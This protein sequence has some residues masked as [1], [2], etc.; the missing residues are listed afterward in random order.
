MRAKTTAKHAMARGTPLKGITSMVNNLPSNQSTRRFNKKV[1]RV[2]PLEESSQLNTEVI[3]Q[4]PVRSAASNRAKMRR[5]GESERKWS[6][7]ESDTR[8]NSESEDSEYDPTM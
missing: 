3:A 6:D 1:R 7:T 4:P 2:Y 5:Y 8:S